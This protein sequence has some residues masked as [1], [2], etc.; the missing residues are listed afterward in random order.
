M[1]NQLRR[2]SFYDNPEAL[3]L[4]ECIRIN[5]K[6]FLDIIEHIKN[7]QSIDEEY[8]GFIRDKLQKQI[9]YVERLEKLF[10]KE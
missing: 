6:A 8:P 5:M 9:E 7:E 2:I 4:V 3:G 10:E 1:N